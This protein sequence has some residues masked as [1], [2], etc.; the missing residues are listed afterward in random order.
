MERKLKEICEKE[1][2]GTSEEEII[3][4]LENARDESDEW[5][6]LDILIKSMT[7]PAIFYKMMTRRADRRANK[8]KQQFE[9]LK[10][11]SANSKEKRK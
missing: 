11:M 7:D 2:V 1:G 3:A 6:Q 8:L 4:G 9:G 10:S 5:K